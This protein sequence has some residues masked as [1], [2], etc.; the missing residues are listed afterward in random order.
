MFKFVQS[1]L[2]R[3]SS[4]PQRDL[5][6]C[7]KLVIA[8]SPKVPLSLLKRHGERAASIPESDLN[9][10]SNYGCWVQQLNSKYDYLSEGQSMASPIGYVPEDGGQLVSYLVDVREIIEPILQL[11]TE[12]I[13]ALERVSR[14]E[15]LPKRKRYELDDHYLIKE[16]QEKIDYFG[17]VLKSRTNALHIIFEVHGAE[18]LC[19]F[20][21]HQIQE[22]VAKGYTSFSAIDQAQDS[23]LLSIKGIGKKKLEKFRAQE[24]DV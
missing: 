14:I 24:Y 16:S 12:L 5:M 15:S 22:L 23:V 2:R 21:E 10:P 13:D 18:H 1:L 6:D 4:E 7:Y 17:G 9:L 3:K 8:M 20:N 19:F 11:E